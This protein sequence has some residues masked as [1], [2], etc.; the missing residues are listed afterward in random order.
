MKQIQIRSTH[1]E[2]PGSD[3]DGLGSDSAAALP[4]NSI[5]KYRSP[6][7]M[8]PCIQAGITRTAKVGL[9]RNLTACQNNVYFLAYG[10]HTCVLQ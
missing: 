10:Q 9:S 7:S 3:C 4:Q 2:V 5:S 8:A 6:E 1:F